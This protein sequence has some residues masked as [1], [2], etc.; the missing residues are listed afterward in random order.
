MVRFNAAFGIEKVD[1][2]F[3]EQR[4]GPQNSDF[5]AAPVLILILE[6]AK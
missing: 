4:K 1:C 3:A 2:R 5:S 6:D